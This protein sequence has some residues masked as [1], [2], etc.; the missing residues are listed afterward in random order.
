MKTLKII[1]I[2]VLLLSGAVAGA[3]TMGV[4]DGHDL[5]AL[6]AQAQKT[7]DVAQEDAIILLDSRT[8]T[9]GDEGTVVTRVHQVV[10]IATSQGIRGYADLRV[11]WNSATSTFEV[12]KLRTWMGGRWWPDAEK[13]S[14]TAVVETLPYAVATADDYTV[15]RETMLLHDG[16]ELPCIMETDYTIAVQG[17]PTAGADGLFVFPQRDPVVRSEYVVRVPVGVD[18]KFESLNGAPPPVVTENGVKEL[19][20]TMDGAGALKR[21]VTEQPEAYEPAVVWTTWESWEALLGEFHGA[22]EAAAV[23]DAALADSLAAVTAGKP[24]GLDRF[25]AVIAFINASVRSVH[26][27]LAQGLLAPRPA[28]RTWESG[29]GH[30]LD[31]AVLAEALLGAIDG[32][33]HVNSIALVRPGYGD[34]APDLPRLTDVRGLRVPIL[35][36]GGVIDF[37]PETGMLLDAYAGPGIVRQPELVM[38][39]QNAGSFHLELSLE[40]GTEGWEGSGL[41]ILFAE[42]VDRMRFQTGA[43]PW[44]DYVEGLLTAILP[45][46]H[47]TSTQPEMVANLMVRTRFAFTMDDP[48]A[49]TE[50]RQRL[51]IGQPA[52]G[53]LANLPHDIRPTDASRESPARLPFGAGQRIVL[54]IKAG[55]HEVIARPEERTIKNAAG[56]FILDTGEH[57]GWLEISRSIY[58]TPDG[59]SW[60][61]DEPPVIVHAPDAWPDLRALLLEELD[62]ANGTLVLEKKK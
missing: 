35:T 23:L 21:P 8:T 40:H 11:P 38:S 6:W 44:S 32:G 10:W 50:G 51:V 53:V 24:E 16:V 55:G 39:R 12:T 52:N 54:R 4:S 62:P 14:D 2:A 57:G 28:V 36:R 1:A 41:A 30:A 59:A 47:L 22:V 61:S 25:L 56:T 31:R 46:A 29:Y 18:V 34:V 43:E 13:I 9:V 3:Q 33:R 5:D 26:G 27:D 19:A 42:C 20:W 58:L 48:E 45:G 49:D 60:G 15:L 17:S 37:D 7:I